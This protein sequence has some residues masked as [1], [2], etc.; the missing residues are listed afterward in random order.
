MSSVT[1]NDGFQM[2]HRYLI[3]GTSYKAG[4]CGLV[5]SFCH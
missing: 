5:R 2:V 4:G 3:N 1:S